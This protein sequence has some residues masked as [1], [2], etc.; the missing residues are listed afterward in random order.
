MNIKMLTLMWVWLFNQ[1]CVGLQPSIADA[2]VWN[3][4][5]TPGAGF[6]AELFAF[7]R[8]APGTTRGFCITTLHLFSVTTKK[9]N[10]KRE[11]DGFMQPHRKRRP[12]YFSW[13]CGGCAGLRH[14][15]LWAD[16]TSCC[17]CRSRG[18]SCFCY[19]CRSG[20]DRGTWAPF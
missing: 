18:K 1:L 2:P 20:Q 4:S 9:M 10:V 19:T 3:G 12:V 16:R 17:C 11:R 8:D 15:R 13:P 7:L 6:A 14:F 5:A